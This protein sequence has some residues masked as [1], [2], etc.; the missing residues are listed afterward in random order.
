MKDKSYARSLAKEEIKNNKAKFIFYVVIRV[1]VIGILVMEAINRNFESVFTCALTLILFL[2]P[3]F[4]EKQ[5]KIDLPNTLEVI[6]ILFI[7]AAEIL[8]EINEFYVIIPG[9][10]TML[11]TINGFI[12]AA[13]GF[14]LVDIF[15]RSERVKFYLSPFFLAVVA[16]CF[17]MTIGVLWEFFE[18]GA[19]L[20]LHTDMQ[21]DTF[22]NAVSSVALNPDGRNIPVHINDIQQTVITA[23]DGTVC[24]IQGYL[25]IGIIDTM[26]DL[27]VN[28]LGAVVFS[29]IGFFYI[30]T[31]GKNK[32]ASRFIPTLRNDEQKR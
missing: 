9:W 30:K 11:H 12:M 4:V 16:F 15:N 13:V 22:V 5:L 28:F 23:K 29:I 14:S 27:F 21:K 6:V 8:G 19:D 10:D 18:F 7:F 2:I 31:R 1:I 24:T 20:F 3:A 17:S 26:K 25:D 32:F